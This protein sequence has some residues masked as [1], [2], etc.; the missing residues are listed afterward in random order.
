MLLKV[1]TELNGS[2][3]AFGVIL[4]LAVNLWICCCLQLQSF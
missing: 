2:S 3:N 4:I 1:E